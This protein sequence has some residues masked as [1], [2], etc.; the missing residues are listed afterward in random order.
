MRDLSINEDPE[1]LMA[2]TAAQVDEEIL[3][4]E[5]ETSAADN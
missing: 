2:P 1:Q 5:E 3:A 4:E